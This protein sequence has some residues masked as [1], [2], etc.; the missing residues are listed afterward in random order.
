MLWFMGLQ[1]VGHD[2]VTELEL[3]W[4]TNTKVGQGESV[5]TYRIGY[6]S[7]KN[8]HGGSRLG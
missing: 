3:D 6:S 5:H 1:R 4:I 2:L 8:L 7:S